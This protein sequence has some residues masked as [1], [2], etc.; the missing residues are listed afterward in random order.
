MPTASIPNLVAK[1]QIGSG[2]KKAL[3]ALL[4]AQ[5]DDI[6]TL[7]NTV[8]SLL[9]KLDTAGGTVPAIGTNNASTLGIA[10]AKLNLKK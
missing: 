7:T 9:A 5:A 8:N 6:A 1:M 2:D 3:S 4:Q 10:A